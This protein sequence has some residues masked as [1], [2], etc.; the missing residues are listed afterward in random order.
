MD[1]TALEDTKATV[2]AY[3]LQRQ[4]L[5]DMCRIFTLEIVRKRCVDINVCW[6]SCRDSS[7][8]VLQLQSP[9]IVQLRAQP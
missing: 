7:E 6:S 2:G 8:T 4:S 5:L 1:A 3:A 9:V